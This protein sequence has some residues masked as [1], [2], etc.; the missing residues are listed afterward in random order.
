MSPELQ[1][2][3]IRRGIG[4]DSPYFPRGIACCKKTQQAG[5]VVALG[6]LLKVA[7]KSDMDKFLVAVLHG[8]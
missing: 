8:R 1:Q 7:D 2:L 6:L 5:I 4:I 3:R